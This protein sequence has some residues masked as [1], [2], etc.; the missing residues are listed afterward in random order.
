MRK[1][2]RQKLDVVDIKFKLLSGKSGKSNESKNVHL[3]TRLEELDGKEVTVLPILKRQLFPNYNLWRT[4]N[5]V[6][7]K[8]DKEDKEVNEEEIREY[9]ILSHKPWYVLKKYPIKY[10]FSKM[11]QRVWK[12]SQ[13]TGMFCVV[14]VF[15]TSDGHPKPFP[16]NNSLYHTG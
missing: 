14:P 9:K 12:A 2:I 4:K 5:G 15:R 6:E 1:Q 10:R 13:N 16:K 7:Y 11:V 3:S 8:E